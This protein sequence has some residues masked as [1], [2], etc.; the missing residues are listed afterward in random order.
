V[1]DITRVLNSFY[2]QL[3]S[4]NESITCFPGRL[5]PR[6]LLNGSVPSVASVT[7]SLSL[8]LRKL[9]EIPPSDNLRRV[10]VQVLSDISSGTRR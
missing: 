5:Q 8:A 3:G 6:L 4:R 2:L 7:L 10:G 9:F 1:G